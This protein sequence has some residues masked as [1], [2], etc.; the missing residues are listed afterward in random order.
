MIQSFGDYLITSGKISKNHMIQII[1]KR[2]ADSPSLAHILSASGI[3][4]PQQLYDLLE[5]QRQSQ[6]PLL[7]LCRQLP[8]WNE[9]QETQ[10]NLAIIE[11][12]PSIVTYLLAEDVMTYDQLLLAL[13]EYLS[14]QSQAVSDQTNNPK[15]A[16]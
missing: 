3:L 16:S 4:S 12:C 9:D 10:L 11:E 2:S 13:D 5:R 6:R 14:K 15:L 8:D 1:L 7:E